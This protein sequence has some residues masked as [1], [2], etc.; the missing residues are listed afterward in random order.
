MPRFVEFAPELPRTESFKVRKADLRDAGVTAD[1][2]DREKAGVCCSGSR[3]DARPTEP[4]DES[5][6]E[7]RLAGARCTTCGAVGFPLR[8]GLS[9]LRRRGRAD[10]AAADAARCGPGRRRASSR[11]RRTS[12]RP[13]EFVP[14]AVGYVELPGALRVEGLLTESEPARL[15][16]G[17]AMEVVAVEHGGRQDLRVR[18]DR[19][20]ATA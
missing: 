14:Y 12:A 3:A 11:S 13:G 9:G 1:T 8:A 6:G 5:T 16:I 7:P 2:W 17:Q 4:L 19:G 18:P 10:P 15:R 20:A